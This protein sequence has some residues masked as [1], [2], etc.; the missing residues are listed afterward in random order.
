RPFSMTVTSHK[1]Y[2]ILE[3]ALVQAGFRVSK[4]KALYER[5]L[6]K[7]LLHKADKSLTYASVTKLG[8]ETVKELFLR[9]LSGSLDN[10]DALFTQTPDEEFKAICGPIQQ[11][12]KLWRVAFYKHEPVGLV[13]PDIVQEKTGTFVYLSVLPE[14]RGRG[15]G[16]LLFVDGL[17]MLRA[18]GALKYLDS[19]N[20]LNYPMIKVFER[21]G[22]K[23]IMARMEFVYLIRDDAL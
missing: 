6:E 23:K 14:F 17:N 2:E 20:I 1:P 8:V 7:P 19:T 5:S 9:S 12:Q 4:H 13:F 21:N 22:C 18:L 11:R 3:E 15:F 16:D 10:V